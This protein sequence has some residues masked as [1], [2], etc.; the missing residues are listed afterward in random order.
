M[1]LLVDM[2]LSP[3]WIALLAAADID[4][5]HWST[6]GA[7]NAPDSEIMAYA[8]VN[9]YVVLTHDLDFSAILAATHGE[10]PSVVQ[11]RAEDVSPDVIG[12][13]VIAA[14]RQMASELE[15]GALLTVDPNRTRLRVLPLQ[16]RL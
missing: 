2:N 12:K 11:I 16:A 14:L 1:K 3:R 6:L 13:Q 8:S 15:V 7:K 9:G 10:K 5:A 4:A